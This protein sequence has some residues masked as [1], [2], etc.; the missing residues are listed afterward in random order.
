MKNALVS[1][2]LLV[3]FVS[4]AQNNFDSHEIDIENYDV[5]NLWLT[6]FPI[7][8]E[9]V[10]IYRPEPLG[11]FGENYQRFN[12]HFVSIIQNADDKSEY[13]AFGKNRLEENISEVIG[14]LKI[15]KAELYDSPNKPGSKE[16]ILEG[17]YTLYEDSKKSGTGVFKGNF[18]TYF[19][20]SQSEE[21]VYN[22][23]AWFADG[24]LNNQF[25]GTWSSYIS[26]STRICNWGDYRIPN[27][28][29]LDN[30]AGEFHVSDRF[31]QFGWENYEIS[32]FPIPRTDEEKLKVETARKKEGE[33]WWN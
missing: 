19:E 4:T 11:Y 14:V 6:E 13:L 32:I 2:L 26:E 25:E 15:S 22:T 5:S 3:N 23:V 33:K 29:E 16:G 12:I 18:E 20:L 9:G 21:I 27:S 28:D 1:I 10:K 8:A 30:G 17:I 7:M 31:I 24:F